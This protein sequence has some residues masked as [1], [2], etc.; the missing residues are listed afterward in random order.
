M[1]LDRAD[2]LITRTVHEHDGTPARVQKMTNL[3]GS[4]NFNPEA[5]AKH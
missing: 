4:F 5:L 3:R 1:I 2:I